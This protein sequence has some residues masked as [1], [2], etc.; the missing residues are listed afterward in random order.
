MVA[1]TPHLSDPAGFRTGGVELLVLSDHDAFFSDAQRVVCTNHA[2]DRHD[3]SPL[4]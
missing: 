1:T 3:D 4:S 2:A